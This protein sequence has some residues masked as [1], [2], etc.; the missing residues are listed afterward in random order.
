MKLLVLGASG[1]CGRWVVRLAAQRGHGV[2]AFVRPGSRTEDH[3]AVEV[4]RGE[5]LDG[6]DLRRAVE[7]VDAVVS[8]LGIRRRRAWNPW[9]AIASPPD[10]TERA[11]G[12][13]GSAMAEAGVPRVVAISAGGVSDSRDLVHPL[14]G[15]LFEHSSI[16]ASYRDLERMECVLANSGMDWQ[17]VRPTTLVHGPPTGRARAVV[18]YGL[19]T[20]VRRADV[21]VW[22]LDAAEASGPLQDRTPMIAGAGVKLESAALQHGP[23]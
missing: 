3:E 5:A 15:W 13:L 21:A 2:R 7:G 9:S 19:R 14:N 12:L 17:A 18:R 4:I 6:G 16:A 23:R 1:G 20:R 11:M 10:L 22:M 8:C